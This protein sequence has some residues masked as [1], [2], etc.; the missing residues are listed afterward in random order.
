[1]NHSYIFRA[2]LLSL[3]FTL[4]IA[5]VLGQASPL[6]RNFSL[7]VNGMVRYADSRAPADGV[8]VQI[9]SFSGGVVGQMVTDRTGKFSFTVQNPQQYVV[10]LRAPGYIEVQENVDMATNTSG[11]VNATLVRDKS[12][13]ANKSPINIS[14]TGIGVVDANIPLEAQN[15]HAKAKTLI[16]E[17][18]NSKI[19]EAVPHLEKAI[20]IFPNYLAAQLMLGTA[21]MDLRQWEKAEKPLL[22]AININSGASTAYFALGEV[23]RRQK[24]YPEAEKMLLDGIKLN[25]DSAEGHNTLAKLYWDM[26]PKASAEDKFKTYLESSWKEAK[27]ALE[28]NPK[29]SEAHLLSGN[30]LLRARRADK[31]LVHFE[32]YIKLEPKGEFATDTKLLV[33]KIKQALAQTGKKSG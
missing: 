5:G 7:Q 9:E 10:T 17:G 2:V 29:L 30:L 11:Y 21:Y 22:A 19:N 24:K 16:D 15:E 6:P 3:L 13:L 14:L 20:A 26:A 12:S 27:R 31:A 33:E 28:L 25:A 4:G 18:K 32:E 8:L 23:Y 1:M